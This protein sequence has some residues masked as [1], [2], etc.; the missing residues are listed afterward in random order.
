[1]EYT[2]Y[3]VGNSETYGVNITIL[4]QLH[5]LIYVHRN[6]YGNKLVSVALSFKISPSGRT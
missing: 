4:F 6:T 5:L 2:L 3:Q 1:M